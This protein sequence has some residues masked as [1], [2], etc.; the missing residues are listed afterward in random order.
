MKAELGVTTFV[1]EPFED[2]YEFV[3]FD[4]RFPSPDNPFSFG[5]WRNRFAVRAFRQRLRAVR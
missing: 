5:F 3:P 1:T 2:G 4:L